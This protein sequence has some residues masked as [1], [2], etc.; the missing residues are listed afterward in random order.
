MPRRSAKCVP[1]KM[2]GSWA[3]CDTVMSGA[4]IL[5]PKGGFPA[6]PFGLFISIKYGFQAVRDIMARGA[7]SG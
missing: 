2:E 3:W 4:S 6:K 1:V 5:A 7:G